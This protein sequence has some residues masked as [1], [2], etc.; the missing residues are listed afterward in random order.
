MTCMQIQTLMLHQ[1]GQAS[2]YNY[3]MHSIGT[4]LK[5]RMKPCHK[6]NGN[7]WRSLKRFVYRGAIVRKDEIG[8]E[9]LP[10]HRGLR[11][12][13]ARLFAGSLSMV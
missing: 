8:N 12:I 3:M 6:D 1:L 10:H 7:V 9:A 13:A 4:A 2:Q 11:L 5:A